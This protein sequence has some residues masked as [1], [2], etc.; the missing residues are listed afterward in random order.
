MQAI[1]CLFSYIPPRVSMTQIVN[2]FLIESYILIPVLILPI[3]CA[4]ESPFSD[5]IHFY[6]Q[7]LIF[8][9]HH[10]FL[11][12]LSHS[13][14]DSYRDHILN[15]NSS[16]LFIDHHPHPLKEI[17]SPCASTKTVI[18]SHSPSNSLLINSPV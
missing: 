18:I 15:F 11:P 13:I 3:S 10:F 9:I 12:F 6:I 5:C 8:Y 7:H 2:S 16:T 17:I 4:T 14:P 1:V